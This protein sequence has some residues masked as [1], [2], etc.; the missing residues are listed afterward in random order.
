LNGFINIIIANKFLK[1]EINKMRELSFQLD[2][3]IMKYPSTITYILIVIIN[4]ICFRTEAQELLRFDS[5][6]FAGSGNCH[7]CH[8]SGVGT[9]RTFDGEDISP[10]FS[11][12][13]SMMANSARDPLWRSKVRA[14]TIEFPNLR[15]AIEDK[16]T[17]CHAPMG[18]TQLLSDG[19]DVY[20][21]DILDEDP[22]GIDGVS[23]TLCHQIDAEGFGEED[24]FS[25]HFIIQNDRI[26]FGPYT[27]PLTATMINMVGYTPEY[28]SH[29]KQSELC[30]VCHTLF[31]SYI[32]SSGNPAG[33][34]PEQTPYLEWE[35]SVYPSQTVSCQSCHM[36]HVNESMTISV[37]PPW[38]ETQRIPVWKHEFV[39][40]NI[41]IPSIF[42]DNA[43]TLGATSS[44]FHFENTIEK[45]GGM[46]ENAIDLSSETHL[47]EGLLSLDVTV[48]NK[49][50]HKF[51]TGF[52]SRRAWLRVH[53]TA[54][55][56]SIL[57][58]S[59]RWDENNE[60]YTP[61]EPYQLHNNIISH[62]N[63]VQIY[64]TV[65]ADE[66][67]EPTMTLLKAARYLKDNRIPPLGYVSDVPGYQD[68]AIIGAATEDNDFNRKNGNEGTGVDI[69]H[70]KINIPENAGTLTVEVGMYYQSLSP[71]FAEDIF[72]H[73]HKDIAQFMDMYLSS[74]RSPVPI[75]KTVSV[76]TPTSV[77]DGSDKIPESFLLH[78]NMP[79]PFNSYTTISFNVFK[80]DNFNLSVFNAAGQKVNTLLTG[81]LSPGKYSV[82][83]NGTNHDGE[84]VP[85][86]LYLYELKNNL[87]K[88]TKKMI[89]IE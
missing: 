32:D 50:G 48:V 5:S 3:T 41:L 85:S 67:G 44:S 79:N 82:K 72:S 18:R 49:S 13:S 45:S 59:G 8:T 19:S 2:N 14:E 27:T 29:I 62:D 33:H 86:G 31:T 40:G 24:S 16:C 66:F 75:V 38:L 84:I 76:L 21:L 26:I 60:I 80:S 56:D 46:L 78:Q 30:A 51:P 7:T 25:G 37:R 69:V 74:Y 87:S 15:S 71:E 63:V 54:E 17:T 57:F 9:F 47:S 1:F 42:K 20:S 4:C 36:P 73:N 83:W 6:L 35:N 23:C 81:I 61:R 65:M 70:Y 10:P 88:T 22:K 52:P 77:Y 12:R 34:F 53:I 55:N 11:W 68:I 89:I 28:S 39:G 43:Q 64:E 58:D